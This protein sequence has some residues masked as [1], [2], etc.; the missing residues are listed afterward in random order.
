MK[1]KRDVLQLLSAVLLTIF[2]CSC[3]PKNTSTQEQL[4]AA[5]T[6]TQEVSEA[7][8]MAKEKPEPVINTLPVRYQSASYVVDPEPT[9]DIA[10][11]EDSEIKVGARITSTTGP[12]PLWDVLKRLVA[13]KGL[14]VSWAS[15]V[16]QN[17]LVDVDIKAND[18]FH[19]AVDNLLRQVDYFHEVQ[20][21]TIIVKYKDTRVFRVNMPFTK[22]V[23]ETGTGGNVLG[24]SEEAANVEGTIKLSSRENEFDIWDNIVTNLD[25]I[26]STWSTTA[27]AI[28]EPVAE[29]EEEGDGAAATR[30]VS[31]A[32]N[33]YTIDKPVGLITVNAPR[34][35][36]DRI[37]VY[38]EN[39]QREM[40]KQ[41]SIEAKIL[42]VQLDDS[43]SIGLNWD[44]ILNNLS[45][46]SGSLIG[47]RTYNKT[48]TDN[49]SNSRTNTSSNNINDTITSV[50]GN[51][52]TF[53]G[54]R[55]QSINDLLPDPIIG[56]STTNT[57]NNGTNN[58][59][60]RTL[61]N[62]NALGDTFEAAV[63]AATII[64]EGSSWAA[65]GAISL[66]AF[67]FAEFLNAVSEQG[68]TSI[69]ANPKLAVLNGQPSLI[70][71]GRNVTYIEEIESDT[72]NETGTVTFT[73]ET[74]RV[75]SG[76][77]MALTAN[78]INDEEIVLNLVPVTSELEEPIEYRQ[79]GL[80]QVGLPIIN[81]RE[82][83]TTVKVANGEMLV[84][85]GLIAGSE[86]TQDSFIPG[87]R[88][89]GPFRYLFGYETKRK[90]K[91]EL[92]ILL[93]PTII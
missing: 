46:S 39:L 50:T 4:E 8:E 18:G 55:T 16:D 61:T 40:Y 34:P 76:V 43:S 93:R 65:G 53:A 56:D 37:D 47:S 35:L 48:T 23:F 87:T 77:G 84:I 67:T 10:L 3:V 22:S 6:P 30:Q 83:S 86:D 42:E 88:G 70:T 59:L 85:G 75:L 19:D 27:T 5:A 1:C 49:D 82:M 80:G 31:A 69:L 62:T 11:E 71:V 91:R 33:T 17:V 78:I 15:D 72:N 9:E 2:L 54:V 63:S 64:T 68:E 29:G 58:S 66:A 32:G 73:A 74:A 25:L 20:G 28:E 89:L 44:L 13:L 57:F 7:V 45:V 38:L 14:N 36:L 41:V 26:I 52:S 21:S 24:S 90:I 51:N 60:E 92:I 12:L 79:I 81:I